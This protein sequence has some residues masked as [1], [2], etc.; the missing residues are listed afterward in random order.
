M[1]LHGTSLRFWLIEDIINTNIPI[2]SLSLYLGHDI[3]P[4]L[5]KWK[6]CLPFVNTD[7]ASSSS[8]SANQLKHKPATQ[9]KIWWQMPWRKG[10]V[11]STF[12]YLST[13]FGWRTKR[14]FYC[15]L[16]ATNSQE[17]GDVERLWIW[18]KLQLA[19]KFVNFEQDTWVAPLSQICW[20]CN[21][22]RNSLKGLLFLE[23]NR[24]LTLLPSVFDKDVFSWCV[25]W[26]Y[27]WSS[28]QECCCWG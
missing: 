3:I 2:D 28:C 11:L 4:Y 15:E 13:S 9:I 16:S 25:L 22:D 23:D 14:H 27:L 26:S 21:L 12:T 10:A 8:F 17:Q 20:N 7:F 5:C 19:M 1:I 18:F 24:Q 6:S